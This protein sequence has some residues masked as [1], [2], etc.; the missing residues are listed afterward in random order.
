MQAQ[1]IALEQQVNDSDRRESEMLT[2]KANLE[3]QLSEAKVS[4]RMRKSPILLSSL[5]GINLCLFSSISFLPNLM[6]LLT[7]MIEVIRI[8]TYLHSN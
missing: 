2:Q 8:L 1:V 5:L 4:I 3:T 7:L 6:T